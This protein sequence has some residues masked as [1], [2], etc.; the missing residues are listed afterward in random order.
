[1]KQQFKIVKL[2]GVFLLFTLL[3]NI[4]SGYSSFAAEH[5]GEK[6]DLTLQFADS[7]D[8]QKHALSEYFQEGKPTILNLV[9]YACPMLCTLVLNGVSDGMKGLK[10]SIGKQFNVITISIDPK[11]NA[12]IAEAKRSA[13][14]DHYSKTHSRAEAKAGWHFFTADEATVKRLADQLGFEYEYNQKERQY[15]HPAVTF[16]LTSEGKIS[17]NLYGTQFRPR[18]LR[19]ALLEASHGKVGSVF[20]RIILSCYQY[21]PEN[22]SYSLRKIRV[23][24]LAA[25]SFFGILG[26]IVFLYFLRK[27]DSLS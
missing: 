20:D 23:F 12:E 8:G 5:L 10:W 19:L 1:M 9:Y 16:I 25:V 4:A 22:Q 14:L 3:A 7:A 18:D 15:E 21:E 17:R 11:D 6:I 26:I 2:N 27:K 24:V 13:Y